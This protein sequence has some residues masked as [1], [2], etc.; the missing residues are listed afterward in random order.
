MLFVYLG[1]G[2]ISYVEI[3]IMKNY[4]NFLL[5]NS[6]LIIYYLKKKKC[7]RTADEQ[8]SMEKKNILNLRV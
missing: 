7:K 1:L 3:C 6:S 4:N 5:V 2:D 8:Y